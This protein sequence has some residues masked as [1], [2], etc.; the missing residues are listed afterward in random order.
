[1]REDTQLEWKQHAGSVKARS[2]SQCRE[3]DAEARLK[4][5]CCAVCPSTRRGNS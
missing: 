5:R 2:G 1:M 4:A 3:H